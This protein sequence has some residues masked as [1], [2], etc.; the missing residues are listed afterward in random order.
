MRSLHLATIA[1]PSVIVGACATAE[2]PP[3]VSSVELSGAAESIPLPEDPR[4]P[5]A[6]RQAAEIRAEVGPV[7]SAGVWFCVTA[8]GHVDGVA[9]K[10]TSGSSVFD[11]AVVKDVADW[12]FGGTLWNPSSLN[13]C[14]TATLRY[15]A[16]Q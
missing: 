4:L 1:L 11:R 9:L 8:D 6:D 14:E 12:E 16:H 3:P 10:Q 5:D 7:A 2:L 13:R 15:R